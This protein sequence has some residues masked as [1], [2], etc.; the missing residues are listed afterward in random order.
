VQ[1]FVT[2]TSLGVPEVYEGA[3]VLDLEIKSYN[4]NRILEVRSQSDVAT[5]ED[6]VGNR[7]RPLSANN[8]GALARRIV[9]QIPPGHSSALRSDEA[10][11]DKLV[12]DRPVPG[13]SVMRVTLDASPYGG[14]G[15]IVVAIPIKGVV[16]MQIQADREWQDT[17]IDIVAE[18]EVTIT[19]KGSWNKGK[20]RCSGVG[21]GPEEDPKAI[22]L[23][24]LREQSETAGVELRNLAGKS[25]E[26]GRLRPGPVPHQGRNEND[27]DFRK[28]QDDYKNQKEALNQRRI[29][30]RRQMEEAQARGAALNHSVEAEEKRLQSR[31]AVANAP[32]MCLVAK[33]GSK[34]APFALPK[35]KIVSYVPRVGRLFLQTND[36]DL[37]ENS[38]RLDVEITFR[39]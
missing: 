5:A 13:A 23:R 22:T 1:S 18:S 27:A 8:D 29:E 26:A 17:G 33:V 32:L 10:G 12:F 34:D 38:G 36:K 7:Y 15:K 31:R 16:K 20:A 30:A 39:R 2:I 21:F 25:I 35:D 14:S 11:T 24:Q 28:R 37:A 19:Y 6:D 3:F 4:P 9:G